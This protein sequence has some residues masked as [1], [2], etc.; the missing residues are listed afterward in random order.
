MA[1]KVF[2]GRGLTSLMTVA[3]FLVMSITG[4]VLYF[5]PEGRVAYWTDWTLWGLTK[6]QWGNIHILS[7]IMFLVAGSFHIYFNWKVPW[8]YLKDKVKGGV[9]LKK[10]LALS[11]AVMLWVIIGGIYPHQPISWLL[12]FNEYLKDAWVISKEYEP[13]FGHA[14]EVSLS[15]LTKKTDIPLDK[16]LA[17]LKKQG[18]TAQPNQSILEIARANGL[19]PMGVFAVIKKH[20]VAAKAAAG[21]VYTEQMVEEKFSGSGIGQKTVADIAALTGVSAKTITA[22]LAALGW[23]MKPDEG[24][25]QAA[26]RWKVTP[27]VFLKAML[28]EG[29]K[30]EQ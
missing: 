19:T 16:A 25:K 10:E 28:V 15:S 21:T 20:Q 2:Q 13:P 17:E 23:D 8:S 5:V 18:Y 12:D 26:G 30:P 29:Y 24:L 9:R 11:V 1:S 7:S 22:H 14:E 27:L 6:I 3:G 4:L